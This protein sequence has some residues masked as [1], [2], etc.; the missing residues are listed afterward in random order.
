MM[1]MKDGGEFIPLHP[2]PPN[3]PHAN[4]RLHPTLATN[5]QP[6]HRD[7][8]HRVSLCLS[9]SSIVL[10]ASNVD[11]QA[12]GHIARIGTLRV[13]EGATRPIIFVL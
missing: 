8:H 9:P 5:R 6:K 1:R 12:A 13:S 10:E 3:F 2:P 7:D 11:S 4:V